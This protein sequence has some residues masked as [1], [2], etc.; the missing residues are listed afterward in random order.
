[1]SLPL[2]TSFIF[3]ALTVPLNLMILEHVKKEV[4]EGVMDGDNIKLTRVKSSSGDHVPKSIHT[5]L[6]HSVSVI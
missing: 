6:Y 4:N 2:M 3:S 5:D 1:M